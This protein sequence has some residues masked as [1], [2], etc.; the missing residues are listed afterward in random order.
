MHDVIMNHSP[1]IITTLGNIGVHRKHP[2][3]RGTAG[4]MH[5]H[6]I[7]FQQIPSRFQLLIEESPL[8]HRFNS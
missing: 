4:G 6:Q 2:G 7:L 3:G 5:H 8:Y 1:A